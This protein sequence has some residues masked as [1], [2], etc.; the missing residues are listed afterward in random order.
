MYRCVPL[1]PFGPKSQ[2]VN[3]IQLVK[4]RG[5]QH[6]EKINMSLLDLTLR[7]MAAL[8]QNQAKA[9][10]LSFKVLVLSF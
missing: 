1:W 8:W 6:P 5:P 7:R 3:K 9:L 4:P 2:Q 10:V